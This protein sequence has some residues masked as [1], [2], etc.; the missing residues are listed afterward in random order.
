MN[1]YR[2]IGNALGTREAIELAER[3]SAWHDAMVAHERSARMPEECDDD[4]P[5]VAAPALWREASRV[6]GERASELVFLRSRGA[7][8][9]GAPAHGASV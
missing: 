3:L 8:A 7:Q 6:F 1:I 5:H 2:M 9:Q 4:C